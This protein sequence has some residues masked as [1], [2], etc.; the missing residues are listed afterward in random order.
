MIGEANDSANVIW[1]AFDAGFQAV[2]E[3]F[4]CFANQIF[5]FPSNLFMWGAV[6]QLRT[7]STTATK[8]FQHI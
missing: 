2:T 3:L 7:V 1:G 4:L 5:Q 6:R 8:S